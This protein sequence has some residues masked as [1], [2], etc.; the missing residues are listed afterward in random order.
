MT[1]PKQRH[2][3]Y[4][5]ISWLYRTPACA[6]GCLATRLHAFLRK[7]G[8]TAQR[9]QQTR[10]LHGD[11]LVGGAAVRCPPENAGVARRLALEIQ[12]V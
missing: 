11:A 8:A 5:F 4:A 9:T 2:F 1:L 12:T 10:R 7:G 6:P 3:S